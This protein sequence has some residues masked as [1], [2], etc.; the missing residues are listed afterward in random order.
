[1]T[2][3]GV[4]NYLSTRLP[5][6]LNVRQHFRLLA[7]VFALVFASSVVIHLLLQQDRTLLGMLIHAT[8]I[9]L[10][11]VVGIGLA[12]TLLHALHDATQ[13]V[14]VWHIWI[15]SIVGFILGYYFLPINDFLGRVLGI[16]ADDH[17]NPLRFSQLLPAWFLVTY[18]FVNPYLNQGLRSELVRLRDFNELLKTRDPSAERTGD[19]MI[20][21]ES[22]RTHFTLGADTIRNIVVDDHY[23]YVHYRYGDGY[24]KR[25][26]A[27]PLR[28]VQKLLPPIFVQVHRSHIVNLQHVASIRR[29]K[30]GLRVILNGG[31]EAP[32]S[33]HRLDE[34]LPLLRRN[35]R[36][37][38][39]VPVVEQSNS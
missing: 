36:D 16:D 4:H 25:D 8:T 15:A 35:F 34:V 11:Y 26:L 33:R 5:L 12:T 32:V 3:E 19:E 20:R 31:Y 24:T 1:M 22:G 37:T 39:R 28:D 9:G 13:A 6:Q 18:L 38:V 17:A 14:R 10:I 7:I 23:C 2:L 30:R 27:M 29:K 21:F